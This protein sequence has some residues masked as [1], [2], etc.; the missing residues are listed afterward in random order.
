MKSTNVLITGA[1]SG[2]GLALSKKFVENKCIVFGISRT[3]KNWKKATALVNAPDKFKLFKADLTEEKNVKKIVTQINKLSGGIDIII[4]NAGYTDK[5]TRV[6]NTSLKEVKKN[7]DNNL[8]ASFFVAKYSIPNLKKKKK[9]LIIN[10]SS[11]A[12]KRAVPN[13]AAYSISKFGVLALSQCIA[14]EN[15]DT[16]LKCVT[17]CP[18]GM[19]TQMREKLFGQ[20]D[21]AKQQSA[22]FVAN[23]IFDIVQDTLFVESGGD[24]VIRHGKIQVNPSPSA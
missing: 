12:G 4:N 1:S 6:E 23:V 20:A 7:F 24:V 5:L 14:K 3:D 8:L 19:N 22:E 15:L 17:V 18:G 21:A 2:L 10:I 13:L 16:G 9:S 11:M